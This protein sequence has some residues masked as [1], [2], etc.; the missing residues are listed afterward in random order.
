MVRRIYRN[1]MS[2]LSALACF[3]CKDNS[4]TTPLMLAETA[5]HLT[6]NQSLVFLTLANLLY[7]VCYGVRDVLWLRIFGVTAMLTI[8][9]YYIWGTEAPQH[10]CICW[11]ILFLAI[12]LFWIV[13]IIRQRQPPKMTE[14]EQQ[15]YDQIFQRSCTAKEMLKLLSVAKE[16]TLQQGIQLVT[17]GS[18]SHDL[19]LV[20]E[21][22]VEVITSG[23]EVIHLGKGDFLGGMSFLSGAPPF[24]DIIADSQI[25]I[26]RW[27]KSDLE[28]LY[29][30]RIELR[31]AMN[32]VIARDLTHKLT[33]VAGHFI[34]FL[35]QAL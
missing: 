35:T 32:E 12:N 24:A 3:T 14:Q 2:Q 34:S 6:A 15:M 20:Q 23:E 27:S 4:L 19:F 16:E 21:G 9:P 11:N 7:V 26:Y 17:K 22:S 29:E 13:V 10:S 1:F 31:A 33:S 25:K 18:D 28:K 8:M 5:R 30:T